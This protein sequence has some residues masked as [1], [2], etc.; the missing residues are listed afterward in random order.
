M[1]RARIQTA[2]ETV[3]RQR[4]LRVR[5]AETVGNMRAEGVTP[6]GWNPAR[7][8]MDTSDRSEAFAVCVNFRPETVVVDAMG[9]G[10]EGK[11][12]PGT[13]KSDPRVGRAPAVLD[14]GDPKR[15]QRE[16]DLVTASGHAIPAKPFGA[17]EKLRVRVPE[18]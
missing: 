3:N 5:W 8:G 12:V 9:L 7:G 2:E 18:L 16:R 10:T 15:R 4:M 13:R 14:S 1:S 6:R 11:S 17:D